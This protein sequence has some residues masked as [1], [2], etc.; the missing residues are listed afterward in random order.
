MKNAACIGKMS[1]LVSSKGD[2]TV[3]IHAV[4]FCSQF[5]SSDQHPLNAHHGRHSSDQPSD[6]EQSTCAACRTVWRVPGREPMLLARDASTFTDLLRRRQ[7]WCQWSMPNV[8][9]SEIL[10]SSAINIVLQ[11][12][13]LLSF[14]V[15]DL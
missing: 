12:H 4:F 7:V 9:H 13:R 6:L 10:A 2:S 5:L 15:W 3:V 11:K 14:I 8:S 1:P